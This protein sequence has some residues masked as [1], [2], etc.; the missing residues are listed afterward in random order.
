M[1]VNMVRV[2]LIKRG[3]IIHAGFK[4]IVEGEEN[5]YS[6]CNRRWSVDDIVIEDEDKEITCKR[7]LKK[8]AKIDKDGFVRL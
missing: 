7:C 3:K 1:E 4:A 6:L 5:T 2:N 8:I